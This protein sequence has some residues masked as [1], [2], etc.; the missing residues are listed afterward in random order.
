MPAGATLPAG[1]ESTVATLETALDRLPV[2]YR[3]TLN[4]LVASLDVMAL[5]Y[6]RTSI[7]ALPLSRRFELLESLRTSASYPVRSAFRL[8]TLALK[9]AHYGTP[10]VAA[11]APSR[12]PIEVIQ[13]EPPPRW[14]SQ[15]VD[16]STEGGDEELEVDVAIVEAGPFHRRS[17]FVGSILARTARM[18]SR[19]GLQAS[20]GNVSIYLPTGR[21]V[22]G[23][24]TINAGTCLR[25]PPWVLRHWR[26]EQQVPLADAEIEPYFER[27]ERWLE[28]A[29]SDPRH[30]GVQATVVARGA[31]ALGIAHGPLLRNAP[32]CDGQ[33]L[34]YFGCPT[35]A[36]RSADVSLIPAALMS[37]A[38]L[39]TNARVERLTP[40]PDGVRVV[41]RS[42]SG[43]S[44]RVQARTAIV[45]GGTL[46]TPLLLKRSGLRHR[47]L[48]KNLSIHPAAAAIA[49]FPFDVRMEEAIPQGY[50]LEGLREQGLL[51]EG[52]ATPFEL[53]ALA[54]NLPGPRLVEVLEQHH[55]LLTYGFNVR[56]TSRGRVVRGPDGEPLP[57]YDLGNDDLAQLRFG[58]RTTL[59]LLARGGATSIFPPVRGLDE[60]D[61]SVASR[62]FDGRVLVPTDLDLS[63]YHPL[64]TARM[65]TGHSRSVVDMELRF[66]DMPSVMVCDGS[67]VPTS[68]GANPQL[69]IMALAAR[70]ADRLAARMT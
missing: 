35:G 53:T 70:A 59:D 28:V 25:T 21:G 63:A 69:T 44:V 64:G 19:M 5:K 56:D 4:A 47:W 60:V 27:I 55:R 41:A 13:D 50:G 24:T 11:R 22:G 30:L 68:I 16:L 43:R 20:F 1:G 62:A 57:L 46:S 52:G 17:D 9:A 66:R 8:V 15:I 31:D 34:C 40:G 3:L 65:G 48:G 12:R 54:L 7:A 6:G 45:A 61:G 58:L 14:A 23:T 42:S 67:V 39:F 29:P 49:M 26:E 2:G 51:F 18:Y 37:G 38:M 10:S 32:G 36:K 33:G